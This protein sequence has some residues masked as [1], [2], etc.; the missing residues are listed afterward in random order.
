MSADMDTDP[1]ALD[2][3]ARDREEALFE[4]LV[5]QVRSPDSAVWAHLAKIPG[6]E[7]DVGYLA[8]LLSN[9]APLTPLL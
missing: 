2:G 3:D 7:E 8:L 5:A 1:F 4:F 9:L 6:R